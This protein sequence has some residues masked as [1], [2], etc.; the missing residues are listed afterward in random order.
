MRQ[1]LT[2]ALGLSV[3]LLHILC[4]VPFFHF[5]GYREYK[6]NKKA[7][8]N[9]TKKSPHPRKTGVPLH[10]SPYYPFPTMATTLLYRGSVVKEAHTC[11][12]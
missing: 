4:F 11:R 6:E 8:N 1:N 9:K 7:N 3:P 10:P 12:K 2:E 5:P